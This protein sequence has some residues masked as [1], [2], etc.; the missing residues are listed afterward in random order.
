MQQNDDVVSGWLSGSDSFDGLENPAGSLY[1]E[2]YAATEA[3]LTDPGMG[4]VVVSGATSCSFSGKN[5][6]STCSCC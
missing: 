2:G 6:A 1:I 5:C 4:K 3:A